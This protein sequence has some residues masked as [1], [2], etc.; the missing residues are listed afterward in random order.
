L[1][2]TFA[3]TP[4]LKAYL[5]GVTPHDSMTTVAAAVVIAAVTLAAG[6]VPARNA[7]SIDPMVSLREE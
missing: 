4:L 3:A 5:F 6:F 7:S 1:I 2:L